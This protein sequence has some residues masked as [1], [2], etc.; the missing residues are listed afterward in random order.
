MTWF[1]ICADDLLWRCL[2][3]SVTV[4]WTLL[5]A[6]F[7]APAVFGVSLGLHRHYTEILLNVFEVLPPLVAE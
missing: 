2:S 5:F 4:W 3:I 1:A 6:V 7:L